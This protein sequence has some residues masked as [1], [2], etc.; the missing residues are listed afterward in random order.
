MDRKQLDKT[1]DE[2]LDRAAADYGK[3]EARPGFEGR[4]IA[5][6]NSRLAARRWRLRW[7]TIAAV[8]T[9][10]VAF[11]VWT[12]LIKHQDHPINDAA[13]ETAVKPKLPPERKSIVM[14]ESET[15]TAEF[16]ENADSKKQVSPKQTRRMKVA[17]Q[18]RLISRP[19]DQKRLLLAFAR[20][21]SEGTVVEFSDKL[22]A[23][24]VSIP[25]LE[26]P[27]I[28]IPRLEIFNINIKPISAP[29]LSG[30]EENL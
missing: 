23:Q 10:V 3:A 27:A 25:K 22:E 28:Q 15:K 29:N 5:N 26:A 24:P 18:K 13:F 1:I 16:I 11:S 6:L 4:I 8:A 14:S 21:A 17:E 2:W 9:V 19:T 20:F 30:N 7:L 12:L